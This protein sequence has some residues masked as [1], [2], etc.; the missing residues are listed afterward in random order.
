MGKDWKRDMEVCEENK[1]VEGEGV[2][3]TRTKGVEGCGEVV[4]A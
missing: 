1:T 2:W 4:S 3:I